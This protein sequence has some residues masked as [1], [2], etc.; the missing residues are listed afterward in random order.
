M[1]AYNENAWYITYIIITIPKYYSVDPTRNKLLRELD[2]KYKLLIY[3]FSNCDYLSPVWFSIINIIKS[4]D[5]FINCMKVELCKDRKFVSIQPSS[6]KSNLL[7]KSLKK[8][9]DKG[10]GKYARWELIQSIKN[11]NPT[12]KS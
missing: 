6:R 9:N 4:S 10:R 8:N 5:N 11:L 1:N 7:L 12:S 2:I 3:W